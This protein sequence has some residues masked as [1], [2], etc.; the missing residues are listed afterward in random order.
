MQRKNITVVHIFLTLNMGGMESVG[1]N[2]ILG[3]QK[4]NV[5]NHVICLDEKGIFAE[6]LEQAGRCYGRT[7]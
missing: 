4:K 7:K 5:K 6:Q 2:L 1:V 3:L